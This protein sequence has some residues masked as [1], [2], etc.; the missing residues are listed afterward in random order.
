METAWWPFRIFCWCY[1][2]LLELTVFGCLLVAVTASATTT[3]ASG[4]WKNEEDA[5]WNDNGFSAAIVN[6]QM[7]D[8]KGRE[9][10]GK[11]LMYGGYAGQ[12]GMRQNTSLIYERRKTRFGR[13]VLPMWKFVTSCTP[14]KPGK[15][16]NHA[17]VSMEPNRALLFGGKCGD[18]AAHHASGK[19]EEDCNPDEENKHWAFDATTNC[20]EKAVTYKGD[21]PPYNFYDSVVSPINK[22]LGL[23]VLY[24]GRTPQRKIT[25]TAEIER[26]TDIDDGHPV[27]IG[28]YQ[29]VGLGIVVEWRKMSPLL[30]DAPPFLEHKSMAPLGPSQIV[31]VGSDQIHTESLDTWI[32]SCNNCNAGRRLRNYVFEWKKHGHGTAFPNPDKFAYESQ[33]Y[34]VVALQREGSAMIIGGGVARRP[35]MGLYV[36]SLAKQAWSGALK[37][38]DKDVGKTVNSKE[39]LQISKRFRFQIAQFGSSTFVLNSGESKEGNMREDTFDIQLGEQPGRP[40]LVLAAHDVSAN[41]GPFSPGRYGHSMALLNNTLLLFGGVG[42]G[43]SASNMTCDSNDGLAYHSDLWVYSGRDRR[44]W[45]RTQMA[46]E[47]ITVKQSVLVNG[48][49]YDSTPPRLHTL[50]APFIYKGRHYLLSFGGENHGRKKR[51][52]WVLRNEGDSW[53]WEKWN[54][55]ME[56][57]I[58]APYCDE[59]DLDTLVHC[60][61][62]NFSKNNRLA[63]WKE[64]VIMVESPGALDTGREARTWLF[65]CDNSEAAMG[66]SRNVS[67]D[68]KWERYR[69]RD[70]PRKKDW[71]RPT[72]TNDSDDMV[73]LVGIDVI[74]TNA[75]SISAKPCS[76]TVIFSPAPTK[77]KWKCLKNA[78]LPDVE[79]GMLATS[80]YM[81]A[82]LFGQFKSY[83]FVYHP[84]NEQNSTWVEVKRDSWV[85]QSY[86]S[87]QPTLERRDTEIACTNKDCT[88]LIMSGGIQT[89]YGT[90]I[91]DMWSFQSGCPP[92]R[93]ALE[94]A[95]GAYYCE[96]CPR[97][98][99]SDQFTTSGTQCKECPVF[100]EA[101]SV[102]SEDKIQ[103]NQVTAKDCLHGKLEFAASDPECR[104]EI[105]FYGTKCDNKCDCSGSRCNI[106]GKCICSLDIGAHLLGMKKCE[107]VYIFPIAMFVIILIPLL[108][109]VWIWKNNRHVKFFKGK[110]EETRQL[111]DRIWQ[112]KRKKAQELKKANRE[113]QKLQDG[114]KIL[115][116]EVKL[117]KKIGEGS[118]AKVYKGAWRGKNVAVKVLNVSAK[119]SYKKQNIFNDLETRVLQRTRHKNL[120]LF[121]GAG[122]FKS[123][124]DFLVSEFVCGGDLR[125]VL[126][127]PGEEFALKIGSRYARDIAAGMAYL[128]RKQI[129][130]R[131]LK[132]AN[133]LVTVSGTCKVTDFGL[134]KLTKSKETN[135]SASFSHHSSKTLTGFVGS[136]VWMAPEVMH[137]RKVVYDNKADVYSFAM[138]MFEILTSKIP[139]EKARTA[140]DV[141]FKV[142]AGKRPPYKLSNKVAQ[143]GTEFEALMAQCWDKDQAARPEFKDIVKTLSRLRQDRRYSKIEDIGLTDS[144]LADYNSAT[145]QRSFSE[146]S[147]TTTD[148][149]NNSAKWAVASMHG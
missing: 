116:S 89:E 145:T 96:S 38:D 65:S 102:G 107:M 13:S 5:G 73:H 57:I 106:Y 82:T 119:K 101:N 77:G 63:A 86:M 113:L 47:W 43:V 24:G 19:K 67:N 137:R 29:K 35:G 103:C 34:K 20:W 92:G 26:P 131:D 114:V 51:T 99:Y 108:L 49:T 109:V 74:V 2:S 4:Y 33:N 25:V 59:K 56:N 18:G 46:I 71:N 80:A 64:G 39:I 42:K 8:E 69:E 50:T 124:Q 31:L 81:T 121:F 104:C 149:E 118:F 93:Y 75:R 126:E 84:H 61:V 122:T 70:K 117:K 147:E 44:S 54:P 79:G 41:V 78:K 135:N 100:R 140:K 112:E 87:R 110:M 143:E 17:M 138:V 66:S 52:T 30:S 90:E 144:L 146:V 141:I 14:G 3:G 120:V 55:R 7:D 58:D 129:L 88:K 130:H 53:V 68:C 91:S 1:H 6:L 139:W 28:H 105:G 60:L 48:R 15:R 127:R 10:G 136:I 9:G 133:I 45:P 76:G 32:L 85:V 111:G 123:G 22:T 132:S 142:L 62:P 148:V 94:H 125:S 37:R 36:W 97:N 11:V 115:G 72:I 83:V 27:W 21:L 40:G 95:T 98:R 23:F 128:H 134:S 12:Y 16:S